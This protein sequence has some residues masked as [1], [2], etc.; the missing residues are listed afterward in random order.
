MKLKTRLL[1]LFDATLGLA[2]CRVIG[3]WRHRSGA[4]EIAATPAPDSIERVLVIR[5]G[6][7][8]DM[9]MLLPVLRQIKHLWPD[10]ELDIICERRNLD[11]LALF[12]VDHTAYAYDAHPIRLWKALRS[13]R[14]DLCIDTEQFHNF[15]AVMGIASGAL[16]RVGYKLNP[17]RISLYT[18]LVSYDV[19]GY[20]LDQFR[21]LLSA[22][23]VD[24]GSGSLH[25]ALLKNPDAARATPD[26]TQIAIAPGSMNRYKQWPVENT[27]T[28]IQ[29]LGQRGYNIVLLGGD[30]HTLSQ[31]VLSRIT[32]LPY[33]RNRIGTCSLAQTAD[34]LAHASVFVGGDSGLMHLAAAL[35]RPSVALFGPSDP[36][37]WHSPQ[38]SSICLHLGLPCSPCSVFGY[39]KLCRDVPC[40]RSIS[41]ENVADAIAK[42]LPPQS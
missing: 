1:K 29:M 16:V 6:G 18:H 24:P 37:K 25:G 19:D 40:M 8:G 4:P 12:D 9:L 35:S 15:S 2:L 10:C 32:S 30:D 7:M 23:D 13:R 14:F 31:A 5:P 39:Q 42:L 3:Y 36:R 33:V 41:A 38:K 28:L 26:P 17:M 34:A 22:V 11:V 20:E 21:R 27:F